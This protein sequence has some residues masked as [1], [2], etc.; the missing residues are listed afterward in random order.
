[1]SLSYDEFLSSAERL[2]ALSARLAG[3][4]WTL[5]RGVTRSYLAHTP[6]LVRWRDDRREQ[7]GGSGERVPPGELPRRRA[8]AAALRDLGEANDGDDNDNNDDDGDSATVCHS[9]P[10]ESKMAMIEWHVLFAL[11]YAAPALYFS[12]CRLD[13]EPLGVG[14]L[15]CVLPRDAPLQHVTQAAHP[16]LETPFFFVHPCET[17][18]AMSCR[19]LAS[20]TGG[21]RAAA[22]NRRLSRTI[23]SA[24]S[25][26]S[27]RA[28][29]DD[30]NDSDSDSAGSESDESLPEIPVADTNA[31]DRRPPKARRSVN[32]RIGECQQREGGAC[33]LREG[34]EQVLNENGASASENY[35]A[36]WLSMFGTPLGAP[37]LPLDAWRVPVS[38]N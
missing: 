15:E 14:E 36:I 16:E 34:E 27:A 17:A 23:D 21:R 32:E 24:A 4:G 37:T 22:A 31:H 29:S 2:V 1:M 20:D 38:V 9:L 3:S 10:A 11:A 6:V 30:S 28:K 25:A 8:G 26:N 7:V 35:I 12:V 18:S 33:Q 19:P 5:R 13:G